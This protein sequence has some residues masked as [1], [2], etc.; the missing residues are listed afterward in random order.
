MRALVLL[1]SVA[2]LACQASAK[3]NTSASMSDEQPPE[4]EQTE[5]KQPS[6]APAPAASSPPAAAAPAAECPLT[7][8]EARGPTRSTLTPEEDKQLRAAL[9][10]ILGRMRSCTGADEWRR[11]GSPTLNLRI[12]PDGTLTDIGFDTSTSG[13]SMCISEAEHGATATLSLPGR[14]VVRCTERC[15]APPRPRAPA[16]RPRRR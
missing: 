11:Y 8:Y 5:P 16:A 1:G 9:E 7:C 3:V 13:T 4:T 10:P 6:S 12:A 15:A 14:K 2:L